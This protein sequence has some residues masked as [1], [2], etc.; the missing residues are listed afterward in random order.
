MP[1]DATGASAHIEIREIIR[2][3]HSSIPL[4]SANLFI[5]PNCQ[6]NVL[7]HPNRVQIPVGEDRNKTIY[8]QLVRLDKLLWLS[9]SRTVF[10]LNPIYYDS[11]ALNHTLLYKSSAYFTRPNPR[12]GDQMIR[13]SRGLYGSENISHC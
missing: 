7:I 11:F 5:S 2:V 4:K 8:N 1:K 10:V 13:R 12:A 3:F 6:S 9:T